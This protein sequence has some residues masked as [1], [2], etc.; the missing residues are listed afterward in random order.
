MLVTHL[1]SLRPVLLLGLCVG[2]GP[3]RPATAQTT[4]PARFREPFKYPRGERFT[5]ILQAKDTE[6]FNARSKVKVQSFLP[7]VPPQPGQCEFRF[8]VERTIPLGK[9]PHNATRLAVVVKRTCIEAGTDRAMDAPR[10][11]EIFS[12]AGELYFEVDANGDGEGGVADP[13]EIE[14]MPDPCPDR[15]KHRPNNEKSRLEPVDAPPATRPVV[16]EEPQFL[17][18]SSELSPVSPNGE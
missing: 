12:E 1:R 13:I 15:D 3:D 14:P 17:P 5:V 11:M 8:H 2:V 10:E 6:V 16:D 4:T 18:R 7:L 9:E